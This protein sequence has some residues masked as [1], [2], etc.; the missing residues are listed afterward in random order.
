VRQIFQVVAPR[1]IRGDRWHAVRS[2]SPVVSNHSFDRAWR[3]A[4]S[5]AADVN[6]R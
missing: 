3:D 4:S 5:Y 1:E 2:L 6:A